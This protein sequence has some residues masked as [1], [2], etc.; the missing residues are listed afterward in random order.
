MRGEADAGWGSLRADLA[1]DVGRV[2]DRL[3]RMSQARLQGEL[4]PGDAVELPPWGSR[5]EAGRGMGTWMS[6]QAVAC[7]A[8]AEGRPYPGYRGMPELTFF[9][10]G[11]QVAV[12]GHDLL[13]AMDLVAPETVVQMSEERRTARERIE[14]TLRVL[15]E[16]RRRL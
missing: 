2:S 13:A 1:A 5:A 16:L 4:P 10:A 8:A 3:R 6:D 9:A 12:G 7:E 14:L 11:D 15:T